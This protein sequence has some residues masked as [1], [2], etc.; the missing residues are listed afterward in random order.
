[1]DVAALRNFRPAGIA[2]PIQILPSSGR[3]ETAILLP[4]WRRQPRSRIVRSIRSKHPSEKAAK[5][6]AES[7]V[8]GHWSLVMRI[9]HAVHLTCDH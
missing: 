3:M 5:T 7:L 9:A 8:A 6:S 2:Q 4:M 1:M